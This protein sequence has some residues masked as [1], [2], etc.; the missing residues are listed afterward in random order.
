V[1]LQVVGV[2]WRSLSLDDGFSMCSMASAAVAVTSY[3]W[4]GRTK[5]SAISS[6]IIWSL[7]R[8]GQL[9]HLLATSLARQL[10]EVKE[11]THAACRQSQS[12]SLSLNLRLTPRTLRAT[13]STHGPWLIDVWGARRPWCKSLTALHWLWPCDLKLH[14]PQ[15]ITFK[16]FIWAKVIESSSL[17]WLYDLDL[18]P[19]NCEPYEYPVTGI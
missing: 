15:G 9:L 18:W 14:V 13:T 12:T 10:V 17:A 3:S 4:G 16:L 11:T 19:L 2:I 6:T 8:C 1:F 5:T 7:S